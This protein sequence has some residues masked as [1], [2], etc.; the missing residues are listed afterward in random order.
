MTH[1]VA[2]TIIAKI[3]PGKIDQLKQLLGSIHENRKKKSIIPFEKIT[4][5]HLHG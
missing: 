3:E 4:T 1:Q 5:I 2:L